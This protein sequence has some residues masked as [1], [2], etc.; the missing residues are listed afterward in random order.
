VL[1]GLL[2]L[3]RSSA[4]DGDSNARATGTLHAV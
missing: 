2:R 1:I 4:G 3:R